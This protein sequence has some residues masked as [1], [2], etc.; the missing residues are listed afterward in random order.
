MPYRMGQARGAEPRWHRPVRQR[1]IGSACDARVRSASH[2]R[3]SGVRHAV[4]YRA[5]LC[6]CCILAH[7]IVLSVSHPLAHAA[8]ALGQAQRA[9]QLQGAHYGTLP[10]D[11]PAVIRAREVFRKVTRAASATHASTFS[12]YVLATPKL[13]AQI[14]GQG[15]V[16]I[17]LGLL[18]RL[19]AA[20]DGLAFVLGHEVAHQIRGHDALL[21]GMGVQSA[22]GNPAPAPRP[23][24][25]AA[26]RALELDADRLGVLYASLAGYHTRAALDAIATVTEELGSD[27]YHPD[28]KA[29]A[30][31]IRGQV[32]MVLDHHEMYLLGLV[33]LTAGRYQ[34]AARILEEFR[35]LY[36]SR[37]VFVNLGV[38][39]HK[40]A[41]RYG[42]DDGFIRSILIDP[43]SRI[44]ATMRGPDS[45]THP[46]FAQYLD[47]ATDAYRLASGMDPDDP[48]A[49]TNLAASY[50]DAGQYE[51]A[52]GECRAAL[53]V[54]GGFVPALN[55]RGIVHAKLGDLARAE[56][57]LLEAAAKDSQ[58]VPAFHNLL[59]V[60]RRLGN[61]AE[62]R[63]AEEALS[64]LAAAPGSAP[65]PEAPSVGGLRSGMALEEAERLLAG[66]AVRRI[67]V[68]LSV[69]PGD[70]VALH[71]ASGPG[72]AFALEGGRVT[73]VGALRRGVSGFP[74]GVDVGAP[75]ER[76]TRAF[77][78]PA[79]TERV[80]AMSFLRYPERGIV[81]YV[82]G[83]RI[84]GLWAV[85]PGTP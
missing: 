60:Y 43:R 66:S 34:A 22:P 63:K 25:L 45:A 50:L 54:D 37:E 58:Y 8:S 79:Q 16:V 67:A 69:T 1:R 81:A 11:H 83:G 12:L 20:E 44:A 41:L 78:R 40:L 9:F 72:V 2:A 55:N 23:E 31:A 51:Y 47:R 33:F 27:P 13:I 71:L 35:N 17:S 26:F 19:G 14:Y 3:T 48:I 38:A 7:L 62:A 39:Y 85:A 68:P 6:F 10:D 70:E 56:A 24:A 80:Q 64:R 49:H 18:E 75:A 84:V 46:L 5:C 59:L 15:I 32:G 53:R 42:Q 28:A 4:L 36:P 21:A 30:L 57:D 65:S 73:A 77:G 61:A 29:R 82:T 74:A 76:L 52:L